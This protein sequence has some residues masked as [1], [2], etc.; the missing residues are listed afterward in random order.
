MKKCK[1]YK[2]KK[3]TKKRTKRRYNRKTLR[4]V[5]GTGILLNDTSD[6]AFEFFIRNSKF[7]LM[8][9]GSNGITI[10]AIL[11]PGL[12]SPY[13]SMDATTYGT[14]IN[15]IIIKLIVHS[16]IPTRFEI[17]Y[18]QIINSILLNNVVNELNI[19]TDIALK[20][21]NYLEPLC[22]SPIYFTENITVEML[23]IISKNIVDS[24]KYQIYL[25][26]TYIHNM[27][28][29]IKE[30]NSTQGISI[31]AMETAQDFKTLNAVMNDLNAYISPSANTPTPIADTSKPKLEKLYLYMAAYIIIKL[32]IDTGYAHGDY[33]K[34]NI[35][36]NTTKT[37]YFHGITGAPLLIDFGYTTKIQP[38][39]M[40]IIKDKYKNKDYLG[41]LQ[42]ISQ[43]PRSDGE[44]LTRDDWIKTY[45]YL[46]S[47]F[48]TDANEQIDILFTLRE[49]AI[50]NTV[51]Q[52]E[53][54][55]A[56]DTTK[57]L[58]PLP[59]KIRHKMYAGVEI[60]NQIV[61]PNLE[62]NNN[63]LNTI[64]IVFGVIYD[65]L[66]TFTTYTVKQRICFFIKF[67]YNYV[68][69]LNNVPYD[70]T[71]NLYAGIALLFID[72]FDIESNDRKLKAIDYIIFITSRKFSMKDILTNIEIIY[73]LF[74]N[75]EFNSNYAPIFASYSNDKNF[76]IDLML[77]PIMYSNPASL[78]RLVGPVQPKPTNL[79]E[80][81]VFPNNEEKEE[82]IL[83]LEE[84]IPTETRSPINLAFKK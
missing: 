44:L 79:D 83:I 60:H 14:P 32:A 29:F 64:K 53:Q 75:K 51:N 13:K 24:D 84:A 71:I 1:T 61:S 49:Q 7:K 35:M 62:F 23:T 12:E 36:I 69:I 31:I 66:A 3:S 76:F 10:L 52:F 6:A 34:A 16:V 78:L 9:T 30:S 41:I 81:Y 50:Q 2:K 15:N 77:D 45:S 20:T 63:K 54:L 46:Y 19:Q 21:S 58:L 40:H 22:P 4:A 70:K 57:P 8:N 26:T 73:T 67:C 72:H 33:H 18:P 59:K 68:Y 82:D 39:Q 27:L 38:E 11:Q 55:H 47:E 42:Q 48:D 17:D 80:Q 5:G 25:L 43:I 28:K 37:N 56:T 65:L 74:K